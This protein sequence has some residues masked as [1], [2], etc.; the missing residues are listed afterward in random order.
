MTG[1]N[2]E[3]LKKYLMKDKTVNSTFYFNIHLYYIIIIVLQKLEGL[4][5]LQ[6]EKLQNALLHVAVK[7]K[8]VITWNRNTNCK[9]QFLIIFYYTKHSDER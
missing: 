5:T 9:L 1:R 6:S 2:A 8:K 4:S 7:E 3:I